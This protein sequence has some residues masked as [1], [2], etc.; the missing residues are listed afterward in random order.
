MREYG[1]FT[2]EGR[3]ERRDKNATT[4]SLIQ[5][6]LCMRMLLL[7]FSSVFESN[8]PKSKAEDSSKP[9]RSRVLIQIFS[10]DEKRVL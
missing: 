7:S 9:M 6:P 1:S 8:L 3:K 2:H 5:F 10:F 4:I